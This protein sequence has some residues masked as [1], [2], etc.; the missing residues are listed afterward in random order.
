M[1]DT[2]SPPSPGRGALFQ[3]SLEATVFNR[4]QLKT[5]L[6][7]LGDTAQ[8]ALAGRSNVGKSTLVNALGRRKALA[9]TSATPGKTRSINFYRVAPQGFVIADLPGYGYARCSMQERQSWAKLIEE[10][11]AACPALKALALLLDCR[12]PPQASDRDLADFARMKGLPLLPV[13]TK[14]DKCSQAERSSRQQEWSRL[15]EG[16]TPL[17]V[18]ARQGLG[19]DALR[20]S[21]C[22]MAAPDA[23]SGPHAS[24]KGLEEGI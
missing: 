23:P 19:L 21:M 9:K 11:L 6:E 8:I 12:V 2:T 10:Y 4:D 1:T 15:L 22:R 16:Q 20:R 7:A 5:Q 13:L 17:P 3:L 18:S 24:G 14:A